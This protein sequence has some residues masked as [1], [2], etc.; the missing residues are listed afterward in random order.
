MLSLPQPSDCIGIQGAAGQVDAP[1]SF[2][3]QD[4][5]ACQKF[6]GRAQSLFPFFG[7]PVLLQAENLGT[8]FGAAIRLRVITAVA[9]IVV[10]VT[11]VFTHPEFVHDCPV[12][13]I[14]KRFYDRVTGAAVCTVDKRIPVSAVCFCIKFCLAFRTHGNVGGYEG[15]PCVSPA[16]QDFE[17]GEVR[18]ARILRNSFRSD[19]FHRR[20][21]RRRHLKF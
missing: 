3:R 12:P 13:V 4:T 11:A 8:A 19:S 9:D 5:A 10:F 20:H 14:G 15:C 17:S 6:L 18:R 2:Y 21:G 7:K 1:D 16:F